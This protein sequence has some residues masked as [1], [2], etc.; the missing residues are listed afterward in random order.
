[1]LGWVRAEWWWM[2]RV[3]A[4]RT[5]SATRSAS[6]T[7]ST[8]VKVSADVLAWHIEENQTLPKGC[9][10]YKLGSYAEARLLAITCNWKISV[11]GTCLLWQQS[12]AQSKLLHGFIKIDTWI[13]ASFYMDLSK[14]FQVFLALA[15]QNQAEVW[16][17]IQSS[18][19]LLHR[20]IAVYW[21]KVLNALDPLCLWQCLLIVVGSSWL[22]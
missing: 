5:G 22:K 13:S 17:R 20:L 14:L 12:K 9:S 6:K 4:Q 8:N 10:L 3:Q 7:A 1:M 19:K 18:L 16:Q 11:V 21:V 2:A 15:K